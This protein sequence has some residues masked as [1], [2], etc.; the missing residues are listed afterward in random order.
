MKSNHELKHKQINSCMWVSY[1]VYIMNEFVQL[2]EPCMCILILKIS[3]HCPHYM[4]CSSYVCLKIKQ[5]MT[6]IKMRYWIKETNVPTSSKNSIEGLK[7]TFKFHAKN[8]SVWLRWISIKEGRKHLLKAPTIRKSDRLLHININFYCFVHL[9]KNYGLGWV[10]GYRL[11]WFFL[12]LHPF[13][14]PMMEIGASW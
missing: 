8:M 12:P 13:W 14:K 7:F 5:C 11:I 10:L 2:P 9:L 4:I 3:S 1:L 6:A